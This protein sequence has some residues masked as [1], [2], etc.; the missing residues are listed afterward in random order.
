MEKCEWILLAIYIIWRVI[1]LNKITKK[2]VI[3]I[4]S[5]TVV[6]VL[7][8]LF[9]AYIDNRHIHI[10]FFLGQINVNAVSFVDKVVSLFAGKIIGFINIF[11]SLLHY[12]FH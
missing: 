2:N 11:S 4:L 7:L 10:N 9:S 1:K 6:G 3:P 12:L 8:G 5:V